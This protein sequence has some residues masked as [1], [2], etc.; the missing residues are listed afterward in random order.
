MLESINQKLVLL[1]AAS[2]PCNE[3]TNKRDRSSIGHTPSS[4]MQTPAFTKK[5]ASD[6]S[7]AEAQSLMEIEV[8]KIS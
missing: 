1:L 8:P 4:Q 3:S 6:Q 7:R 2:S 5:F